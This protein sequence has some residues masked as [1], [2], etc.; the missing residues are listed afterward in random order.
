MALT[1]AIGI[2]PI[3]E[4]RCSIPLVDIAQVHRM[5]VGTVQTIG[6][7]KGHQKIITAL[8]I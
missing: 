4:N 1:N 3:V 5:P 6:M 8:R 7:K 2:T